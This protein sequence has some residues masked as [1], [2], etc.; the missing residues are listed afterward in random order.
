M[1]DDHPKTGDLEVGRKLSASVEAV[2]RDIAGPG[3][4]AAQPISEPPS[5]GRYPA[6]A[7]TATLLRAAS[8]TLQS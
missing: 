7:V 2:T 5:S 3:G 6:I 8:F 4:V 1:I